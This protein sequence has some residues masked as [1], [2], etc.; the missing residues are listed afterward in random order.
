M[1]GAL[2]ATYIIG[3]APSNWLQITI[4]NW[5]HCY[6]F[7]GLEISFCHAVVAVVP[8]ANGKMSYLATP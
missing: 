1:T 2:L 6:S 5:S 4:D 8:M 3:E 7:G